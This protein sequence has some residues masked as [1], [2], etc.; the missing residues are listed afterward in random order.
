MV[1]L[2]IDG[3]TVNYGQHKVLSDLYVDNLCQGQVIALLGPNGSGKSTLLKTLA[4]HNKLQA[5]KILLAGMDISGMSVAQRAAHVMYMPQDFPSAVQLSVFESVLVAAQAN[6]GKHKQD[7]LLNSVHL[8]L[9]R[10]GIVHLA[11]R[12]LGKLSGGQRQLVG[13]AQALIRRPRLLLLDEP[14]SALDLNY[15]YHVMQLLREETQKQGLI[16]IVVLHDLN[17]ALNHTDHT[18]LLHGGKIVAQG[19]PSNVITPENIQLVYRVC[20]HLMHDEKGNRHVHVD[21]LLVNPLLE[22]IAESH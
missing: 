6:T 21:G 17:T 22:D 13:L 8:L 1:L 10:L 15:Q 9:Q 16:T 19:A 5:G 4:G 3:L 18:L 14:L 7:E 12:L 2:S 11:D 20:S